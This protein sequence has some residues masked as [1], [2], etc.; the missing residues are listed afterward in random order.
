M[1]RGPTRYLARLELVKWLRNFGDSSDWH[2]VVVFD[3]RQAERGT[4]GGKEDGILVMYS[5]A[6]E[7]AD[8]I[9]ERLAARFSEKDRVRVASDDSMVRTT[10][11]AFGGEAV[12][13]ASLEVMVDGR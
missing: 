2:V 1:H 11:S 8:T 6:G 12:R 13:I 4:E 5:R 9:I 3:G 10:V 7:T